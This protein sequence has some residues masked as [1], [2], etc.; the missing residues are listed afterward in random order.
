MREGFGRKS[1]N[2]EV[3]EASDD[4]DSAGYEDEED[5][6]MRDNVS[7][8]D[9]AFGQSMSSNGSFVACLPS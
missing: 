8:A 4:A 3:E 1:F 5:A 9:L 6:T 7:W 2:K